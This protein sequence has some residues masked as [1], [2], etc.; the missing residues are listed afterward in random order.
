VSLGLRYDGIKWGHGTLALVNEWWWNNRQVRTWRVNPSEPGSEPV[1]LFDYSRQDRYNAPGSPQMKRLPN[2][3]SVLL[4]DPKGDSLY[5]VGD[6][7]S[8]EGD[9]PF[10][11]SFNVSEKARVRLWRS[12]APYYEKP[13]LVLDPEG[14][15]LLTRRESTN[16]PPNYFMRRLNAGGLVQLTEFP[17][18]SPELANVQKKLLRY[19]RED[20]VEMTAML[21]LPAGYKVEDGPLPMLMWAYPQEFS[22]AKTAGQVTVS[23]Y[24]FARIG[25]WSPL[26]W[27]TSGYAVLDKPTMPI[28]GEGDA[29]PND[30]YVVQLIAS[31]KAAVDEV[32]RLGV[33]D[34]HRI[35]IGGHSYGAFMA[36]NLLA[37]SD[38]YAAG[39]ARSGAYNR[40]LTPFGFQ[41]E[42]RTYWDAPA[43]YNQMSAFMHADLVNEPILL[44]HGAAD[45][46][47]GTYPMQSQRFYSALSGHGAT[48]RLVMLPHESHHYKAR[49]SIMHMLWEMTHWLD[50]YV[51]NAPPGGE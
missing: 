16:E 31:A 41:A 27:L 47:S 12:E 20:G 33:A 18:P 28:V 6:G 2:G 11:D 17:H 40:T 3:H 13:V 35:A 49:E 22:S 24:R 51:R 14:P 32:V 7:A 4:T 5:L 42:E 46:N 10:I 34:R 8:P 37:H 36:A 29:E 1:L 39:I 44:I 26:F 45:N 50:E 30:T 19:T 21:Y 9:R 43:V 15:T 38:L 23:P 48:V 25:W